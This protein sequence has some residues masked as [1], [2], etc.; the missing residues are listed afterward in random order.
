LYSFSVTDHSRESEKQ[1]FGENIMDYLGTAALFV[2]LTVTFFWFRKA[3]KVNLPK[4][5]RVFQSFWFLSFLLGIASTNTGTG[6][7][8]LWAIG[9]S[10]LL[11][12]LTF[13]GKQKVDKEGIGVGDIIPAFTAET[14]D[15]KLFGS[16]DL[17]GSRILIKFFRAHW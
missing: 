14:D 5:P 9:I 17:A 11:L 8:G 7:A 15:K 12:V 2:A 3:W 10:T 4:T 16:S 1:T 13:T 6:L